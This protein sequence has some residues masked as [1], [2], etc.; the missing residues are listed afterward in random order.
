MR[1]M[2]ILTDDDNTL[3]LYFNKYF[4]RHRDNVGKKKHYQ[5]KVTKTPR[6]KVKLERNGMRKVS[7]KLDSS[8]IQLE[9]GIIGKYIDRYH[10]PTKNFFLSSFFKVL[11]GTRNKTGMRETREEV[12]LL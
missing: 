10:L 9:T 5:K 1:V 6:E 7:G 12:K 8:K 2:R 4:S 3:L 11:T